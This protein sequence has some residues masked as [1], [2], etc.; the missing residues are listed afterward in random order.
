ML[1]RFPRFGKVFRNL[2]LDTFRETIVPPYR[3]F[4][5]IDDPEHQIEIVSIWHGAR[6]EP[7]F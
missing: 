7:E 5:E 2:R 4:Y 1:S 3:I 6:Q